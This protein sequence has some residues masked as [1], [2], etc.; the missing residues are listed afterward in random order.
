MRV[1]KVAVFFD[2]IFNL[3]F[4]LCFFCNQMDF[5]HIFGTFQ[6]K[7][8]T[9]G[10]MD[11]NWPSLLII[12][13]GWLN[14][15]MSFQVS[16]RR[17]GIYWTKVKTPHLNCFPFICKM[18]HASKANKSV[19]ECSKTGLCI[20]VNALRV[21]SRGNTRNSFKFDRGPIFQ[22]TNWNGNLTKFRPS[23]IH[24]QPDPTERNCSLNMWQPEMWM[25][26]QKCILI[27]KINLRK[28][29]FH[30]IGQA[31]D[32]IT[33]ISIGKSM[34]CPLSPPGSIFQILTCLIW[35]LWVHVTFVYRMCHQ[36][37]WSTRLVYSNLLSIC[38][39]TCHWN[40]FLTQKCWV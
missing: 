27:V 36:I 3:V 18:I 26:Y 16:N 11:I 10:R 2:K 17:I 14:H 34:C 39:I 28:R 13:N 8:I 23:E 22:V 32:L 24:C 6:R 1:E 19:S 40:H 35:A 29:G 4:L 33:E 31:R 38:V 37:M 5:W 12:C 9:V 25:T 30:Q 21:L 20:K 7:S 15:S